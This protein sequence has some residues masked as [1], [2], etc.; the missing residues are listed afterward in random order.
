MTYGEDVGFGFMN[1]H[2]H[3]NN[4]ETIGMAEIAAVLNG[5]EF[6]TRHNDYAL[7]MPSTTRD[8]HATDLVPFP[9]VPPAVLA[10]GTV[11]EQIVEMREWFKAFKN[12]DHSVRD[13]R[14][15][16]RPVLAYL[17]GAWVLDTDTLERP[18]DSDR[19]EIEAATW[20]EL[21]TKS[22]FLLNS[23]NK[24]VLENMPY[25]P[26]AVRDMDGTTPV[27]ANW[28]YRINCHPIQGDIPLD[29]F[30]LSDDVLAQFQRS[31]FPI[32]REDLLNS[33][34]A[35]FTL[36]P[37]NQTD[38]TPNNKFHHHLL[39]QIMEQVPGKDNYGA[40]LVDDALGVQA[41]HFEHAD[42]S[43]NVA[44]YSRVYR[45]AALDA[46]GRSARRRGFHD[47]NL[48]AA[49]TTQDKISGLKNEEGVEQKWTYAIPLEII[50]LTPLTKWNPYDI[51]Y[52]EGSAA[53]EVDANGRDGSEDNPYSGSARRF[54]Y[55]TPSAFY[56]GGTADSD[57]ADTAKSSVW[58][59]NKFGEKVQVGA[60]G[61]Y[62]IMPEIE[63][64]GHVRQ[65]WPI[66]PTHHH[67]NPV[68]KE[69]KATTHVDTLLQQNKGICFSLTMGGSDHAHEVCLTG[70]EVKR[71][72][73]NGEEVEK[74]SSVDEGHLHR[75]TLAF[76]ELGGWTALTVSGHPGHGFGSV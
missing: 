55:R 3:A 27:F 24:N 17:E 39:D 60:S 58:V 7:R 64:V 65:R 11:E 72:V 32:S 63:G 66:A 14:P 44:Y 22:R 48:F 75:V 73:E 26:S 41:N 40:T 25:L 37:R 76:T 12:Q 45:E 36:N 54:F 56:N 35:H 51:E 18:F 20:S 70:K 74:D 9:D 52:K 33:R 38:T 21:H 29:R 31:N 5:V 1:M 47:A 43:L 46:V 28:E 57:P 61:H 23:G 15:Y 68:Y 53:N 16:F 19:H 6:W 59:E 71:A 8:Y 13:Y 10:K 62:T 2:D 34:K 42:Q 30:H 69:L 50:Y 4:R 49:M 67:T